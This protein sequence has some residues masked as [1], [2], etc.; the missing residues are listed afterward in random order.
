MERSDYWADVTQE[1]I[2]RALRVN[3]DSAYPAAMLEAK[4]KLLKTKARNQATW[5]VILT[6]LLLIIGGV[7]I[8]SG[9][10]QDQL[11]RSDSGMLCGGAIYLACA[12]GLVSIL[13]QQPTKPLG[14]Q[15]TAEF[16]YSAILRNQKNHQLE[17]YLILTPDEMEKHSQDEVMAA[18]QNL[19]G[20]IP[21]Q[22]A[23]QEHTECSRC[24]KTGT[25]LWSQK[26]YWFTAQ[27]LQGMNVFLKCRKCGAVYCSTCVPKLDGLN[28]KCASCGS[29]MQEIGPKALRSGS[30]V[31]VESPDLKQ[32][33]PVIKVSVV[34]ENLQAAEVVC[35]YSVTF[36]LPIIV[37]VTPEPLGDRGM[38]TLAFHNRAVKIGDDWRLLGALPGMQRAATA[39]G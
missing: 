24:H 16:Y 14:L 34:D 30:Q 20:K 2:E 6:I 10:R 12:I 5:K 9:F 13:R 15:K 17:A 22:A 31:F 29:P 35:E 21:E 4:V 33:P 32:N 25:G 38:V 23:A 1:D 18:W 39:D 8:A 27:T 26:N 3:P 28:S 36:Q 37:N 19:L 11:G 7:L